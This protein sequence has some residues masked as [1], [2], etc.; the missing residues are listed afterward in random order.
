MTDMRIRP[1]ALAE[2]STAIDWA[3]SEGWN[4][5]LDDLAAFHATDPDG[6]LM[7]FIDDEPVAAISVVRYSP[8]F[9]FLGFYIVRPDHRGTGAGLRLWNAGMARLEGSTVGLDGVVAQ[10]ENYRKSGFVL[11]GRNI[12][13]TGVPQLVDAA[14]SGLCMRSVEPF[15]IPALADFDRTRF[16]AARDSF[17]RRWLLPD[18][19]NS[20]QA[21]MVIADKGP[22][23]FG[24]M[25]RCRKGYK[26][27]P[28]FAQ[29]LEPAR[30]LFQGLCAL[31]PAGSE[32][33]LDTPEDNVPAVQLA[34]EAGLAP[35]FET[36]RMYKGRPPEIDRPSVFGITSF[37]LG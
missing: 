21:L 11:D 28:L 13:H 14:P 8:D 16:G 4:P 19:P 26:I 3:A 25:R 30:A 6:F 18:A 37:E 20:R 10:Q 9:G 22:I 17:L 7:G 23:G 34:R 27:G 36:A 32:V 1:A 31:V 15:D 29:G 24:A 33:T 2:F 5:G 12:R 35:V